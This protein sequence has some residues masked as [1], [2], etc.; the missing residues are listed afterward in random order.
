MMNRNR[1]A[2]TS[3]AQPEQHAYR[4][5]LIRWTIFTLDK[6]DNRMWIEKDGHLICWAND[7]DDAKRK[8]DEVAS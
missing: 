2:R 6:P 3:R 1:R 7:V 4:G 8:I 5:Y